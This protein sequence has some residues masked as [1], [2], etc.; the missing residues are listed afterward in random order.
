MK[1]PEICEREKNAPYRRKTPLSIS[2]MAVVGWGLKGGNST[3][4]ITI[5]KEESAMSVETLRREGLM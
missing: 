4:H 2:T 5:L 1:W 3:I